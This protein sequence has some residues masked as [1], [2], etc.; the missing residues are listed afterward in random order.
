MSSCR[1]LTRAPAGMPGRGIRLARAREIRWA[2]VL[3]NESIA[4]PRRPGHLSVFSMGDECR[5][6]T[7]RGTKY[8]AE[9]VTLTH[10]FPLGVSNSFAADVAEISVE[11]GALLVMGCG[12]E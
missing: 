6:V 10:A 2:R 7:L 5:G 3:V 8:P 1:V 9:D 12:G 4:V 11:E